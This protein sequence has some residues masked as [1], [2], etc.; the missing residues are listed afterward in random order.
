MEAGYVNYL[1]LLSAE[2]AYQQS[3]LARVQAQ[4]TASAT[5][6]HCSRRLAVAV[7]S[8]RSSCK[9]KVSSSVLLVAF[10]ALTRAAP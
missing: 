1:S 7:E 4:A 5:P 2:T 10:T 8:K 9:M 6:S 3:L